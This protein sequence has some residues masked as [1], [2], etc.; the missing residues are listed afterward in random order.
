MKMHTAVQIR[1]RRGFTPRPV[2]CPPRSVEYAF[3]FTVFYS[4]LS[5]YLGVEVPFVAAGMT[6][7]VAGF[8]W[9]KM[10]IRTKEII[11]PI[12]LLLACILSYVVLQIAV[13]GISPSDD[14][15]RSFILWFCG[16]VVVQSLL[17]RHGFLLRC[18]LFL[19]FLALVTVPHLAFRT[20]D[21]VDRASI[22][23]AV[24]GNLTN[25]NGLAGWFGFCVIV[26]AIS[27]FEARQTKISIFYWI[28]AAASLLVVG[29]TVS[30]GVLLGISFALAVGFR[31]F[32]KR[33]FLPVLGCLI[34]AGAIA[35][36]GAFDQVV[37]NYEQRGTEE[38]GRGKIW[39]A[40]L[41]R[42]SNSPF[43]GVGVSELATSVE[44]HLTMP[45]NSFLFFGLTSGII[46]LALWVAFW[47]NGARSCG[48]RDR[49]T[50][51]AYR[52][53]LLIYA[54]STFIFGDITTSPWVLLSLAVGAGPIV[55]HQNHRAV[56]P[57]RLRTR[58]AAAYR[59]ETP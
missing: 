13:H 23:I 8:C 40:V 59:L 1:N 18:S 25:A 3:Y 39:P 11:A 35:S 27:G 14:S 33:G 53:P 29:L 28:L 54:L 15:I 48:R 50:Y 21:V 58:R 20:P 9:K 16:M 19:F 51:S 45:H 5:G 34:V 57:Y 42:I 10:G 6:V 41:E 55:V 7:A 56:V 30:R 49:S 24:A 4:L 46:P 36:S 47:V 44:G 52:I 38:T 43:I 26:F 32:L 17:L 12:K 37:S 22:D 31:R 2:W